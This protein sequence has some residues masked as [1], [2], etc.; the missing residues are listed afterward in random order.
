MKTRFL[1]FIIML[2]ILAM[3]YIGQAQI[4]RTL[5]Y[6]GVLSDETGSPK[7]DGSYTFTFTLYNTST[8]DAAIWTE[9]KTLNVARG[10]FHTALG[11]LEPFGAAVE[12]EEP[13][14]LGILV[15]G[16]PELSPR[17]QLTSVGYS[18]N[19]LRADTA[20]FALS[21]AGGTGD[22]HSLDAEDGDPVDAGVVGSTGNVGIGTT[23]PG[24]PLYGADPTPMS[25]IFCR[26]KNATNLKKRYVGVSSGGYMTF[27]KWDDAL[28]TSTEHMVIDTSGNVGIG[29]T[30]PIAKLSVNNATV[31]GDALTVAGASSHGWGGNIKFMKWNNGFPMAELRTEDVPGWGGK[32]HFYTQQT[33]TDASDRLNNAMTIDNDGNVGI[34]TTSPGSKLDV[35][36]TVT[37]TVFVGDGSGLTGINSGSGDASYGSSASSPT[38]AVYV[39]ND[40][41]VL[42]GTTTPEIHN[43]KLYVKG[44]DIK[45][46]DTNAFVRFADNNGTEE[47]HIGRSST[48]N[49]FYIT[50]SAVDSRLTILPTSGNVG[51]GTT[52][53]GAALDVVGSINATEYGTY[54]NMILST[55]NGT[56]ASPTAVANGD[57]LGTNRMYG[58]DGDS[59][60]PSVQLTA[61]V[62][63]DV[64]DG[65]VPGEFRFR[66][67]RASD[68]N[69]GDRMVIKNDGNI[70]IGTTSPETDIEVSASNDPDI[71][72]SSLG[73]KVRMRLAGGTSEYFQL[74]TVSGSVDYRFGPDGGTNGQGQLVINASG[75]IGIGETNP[76]NILTVVQ[77]STTDPIAD[78]WTTYSSRRWK[79][80][81]KTINNALDKVGQLRGVTY[82]WKADGKHDM[83]LIAE[84]VGE[85]IPEVVAYEENGIDAKS[86]DY[87]RLVAVLIEA[88]KEQQNTIVH[89]T[90]EI[91]SLKEKMA[92]FES[93]LEKLE[94]FAADLE[95]GGGT[96]VSRDMVF[97]DVKK[98]K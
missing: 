96:T 14:W 27:G 30:S 59:F 34:G 5:S 38:D 42:I 56:K 10:L 40:G 94:V 82:D 60:E 67:L 76:G 19:A 88:V 36:G 90:A 51:I 11:D 86:V 50:E 65:R 74:Y 18:F 64:I 21:A 87:A 23:R 43:N 48:D 12:F 4:P 16:E 71:Q 73:N 81:I 53:P 44:G 68:G 2:V 61:Y 95:N 7:P 77:S 35:T 72:L 98:T 70:G 55:A 22:G 54:S 89:Q 78:A 66:T 13:Y 79:T 29:T 92:R 57:V 80:N 17:I 63:G 15:A 33:G 39:D 62:D 20:S 37:A 69:W 8:G 85:V 1:T 32:L 45:V 75:N 26:T 91:G 97:I 83:G 3:P 46:A 31:P 52:S 25:I 58:F 49:G 28:T 47:W 9:T 24:R 93:T 41:K 84:E 6:Q